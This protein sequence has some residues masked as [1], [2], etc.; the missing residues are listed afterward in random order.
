MN[1]KYCSACPVSIIFKL[2]HKTICQFY[3]IGS[4]SRS[5]RRHGDI[6]YFFIGELKI[7]FIKIP[8]RAWLDTRSWVFFNKTIYHGVSHKMEWCE[9]A[10]DP[11]HDSNVCGLRVVTNG[12]KLFVLTGTSFVSGSFF[13]PGWP[14]GRGPAQY[15]IELSANLCEV[16][17]CPE[18]ALTT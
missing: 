5:F 1:C 15:S 18:K 14:T 8:S 2:V 12:S 3:C 16:S 6:P 13:Q 17:Q 4:K 11:A 10:L 9:I 7:S